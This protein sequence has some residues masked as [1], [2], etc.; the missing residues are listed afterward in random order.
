LDPWTKIQTIFLLPKRRALFYVIYVFS[1][2]QK[3]K[4]LALPS[5]VRTGG[6]TSYSLETCKV[7]TTLASERIVHGIKK[8]PCVLKRH[9]LVNVT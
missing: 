5:W 9:G 1:L 7:K 8:K 4:Q 3:D 6:T 2:E